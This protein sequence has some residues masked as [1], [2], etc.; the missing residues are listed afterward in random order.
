MAQSF[1][2]A[3]IVTSWSINRDYIA[4]NLCENKDVKTSKCSGTCYLKKQ[5]KAQEQKE[6]GLPKVQKEKTELV[7]DVFSFSFLINNSSDSILGLKFPIL[8]NFGKPNGIGIS[9]FH[10]PSRIV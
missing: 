10:P 7:C 8:W 2:K 3:W 1:Q 4:A 6:Q 5:L 9:I